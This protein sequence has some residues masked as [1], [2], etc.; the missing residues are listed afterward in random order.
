MNGTVFPAAITSWELTFHGR[1]AELVLARRDSNDL[2]GGGSALSR[3]TQ[4]QNMDEIPS[5]SLIR[6]SEDYYDSSGHSQ[7]LAAV[8]A[9]PRFT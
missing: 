9:K 4:T 1:H 8:A 2:T 3:S 5:L 6:A 7:Y